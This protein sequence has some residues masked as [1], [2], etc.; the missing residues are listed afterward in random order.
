MTELESAR[1]AGLRYVS[2]EMPGIR[3]IRHGKGFRYV[4]ERGRTI[5]DEKTLDR[6]RGLVIPPAWNEVWICPF[7]HGHLQAVGRD[8]RGRKQYRYHARWREVRDETKFE[9]MVPF[10]HALPRIRRRIARD[11]RRRGLPREKVLATVVALL[12]RT[13]IRIGNEEYAKANRSYGLTTLRTRHV[14]VEGST[15]R[16]HFRGKSGKQHRLDVHDPHLAR[17][18][19][20]LQ[21]LPGE[22]LFEY[23]D[24]DGQVRTIESGDVNE[25]LRAVSGADF[26]AKDFRTWAGTVM[27][28]ECLCKRKPPRKKYVVAAIK[29]VAAAL[30]NTPAVCRKAYVHP[31]VVDAFLR[32]KL[33]ARTAETEVAALIAGSSS[34]TSARSRPRAARPAGARGAA[35][36]RRQSRRKTR[37][38]RRSARAA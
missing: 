34:G 8:A 5:T 20:R 33:R 28:A 38:T 37:R 21:D 4:D 31:A 3:R 24:D 29:E 7:A 9:R 23:L 12:E 15:V 36:R 16:F 30:G 10:A 17:I 32:G 25:Y 6:I 11:L 18:V 35:W 1:E 13:L 27:A 22:L 2:D 14:D 19:A 26:T